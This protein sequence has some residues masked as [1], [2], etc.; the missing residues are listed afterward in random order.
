[1]WV[2]YTYDFTTMITGGKDLIPRIVSLLSLL[3]GI[4]FVIRYRYRIIN[5]VLSQQWLRSFVIKLTMQ[6]PFV[7]KKLLNQMFRSTVTSE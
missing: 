3:T 4:F 2:N 1:M 7:R 6:I 5:V